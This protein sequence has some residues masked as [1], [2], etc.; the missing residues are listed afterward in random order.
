[1]STASRVHARWTGGPIWAAVTAVL[2]WTLATVAVLYYNPG[3]EPFWRIY[4]EPPFTCNRTVSH[5]ASCDQAIQT[6]NDSWNWLHTY[7]LLGFIV[8]GYLAVGVIAYRGWR[9]VR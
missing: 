5:S 7:P 4:T 9:R 1:M 2:A 6:L 8:V 3:S